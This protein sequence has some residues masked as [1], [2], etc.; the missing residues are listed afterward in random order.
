MRLRRARHRRQI[1]GTKMA[2]ELQFATAAAG[3]GGPRLTFGP[4]QPRAVKD[5]QIERVRQEGP[6]E[7]E[8]LRAHK[9]NRAELSAGLDRVGD[10]DQIDG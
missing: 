6:I 9:G 1:P 4:R 3:H 10:S 8:E 5:A 2:P 7:I